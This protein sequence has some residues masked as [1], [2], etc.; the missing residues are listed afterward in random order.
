MPPNIIR[1]DRDNEYDH[2]GGVFIAAKKDL[3]LDR[4]E[5]LKTDCEIVWGKLKIS[6]SKQLHIEAYYRPHEKDEASLDQLE[7][8]LSG[9]GK[10]NET[11]LL[12][13]DFL[14]GTGK[15]IV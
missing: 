9:I 8:S 4:E 7:S 2:N 1:R 10:S 15:I 6:G 3:I 11:I 12:A 5:E 13:G 14:V